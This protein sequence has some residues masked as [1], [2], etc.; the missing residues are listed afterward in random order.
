MESGPEARSSTHT[1]A[2]LLIIS[3]RLRECYSSAPRWAPLS[4]AHV[5]LLEDKS[6]VPPPVQTPPPHTHTHITT[7][8]RTQKSHTHLAI[9]SSISGGCGGE[10]PRWAVGGCENRRIGCWRKQD[11]GSSAGV[12]ITVSEPEPLIR[13]MAGNKW[14][15][16][17]VRVQTPEPDWCCHCWV[18][19]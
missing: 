5:A 3:L 4:S 1:A 18:T 12:I 16:N 6:P 19:H 14:F 9:I 2:L 10:W 11:L 13:L 17:T 8:Q 7:L 15:T